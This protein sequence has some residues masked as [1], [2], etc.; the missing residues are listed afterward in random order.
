MAIVFSGKRLWVGIPCIVLL[1]ATMLLTSCKN[2]PEMIRSLT[3][4][5]RIQEDKA[6]G[7]TF[8]YSQDGDVKMRIRTKEFVRN[9]GA[10]RPYID[11][12]R[13]LKIEFYN[14]SG[15]LEDVLTAVNA[16]YYENEKDYIVH[17]SVQIVSKKGEKLNTNEL[18]W[19][20]HA[21]KFFTEQPVTIT[22]QTE[23]LYGVGM[24][25]NRDFTWYKIIN[26]KGSVQVEKGELPK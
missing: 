3:S 7:V 6:F 8:L 13:G 22:T 2:D 11:M 16:R 24:E 19:N 4:K 17:D 26:P 25:A 21:Q 20:E 14:D 23:V 15:V 9:T 18:V 12:K 10:K 1:P 5:P